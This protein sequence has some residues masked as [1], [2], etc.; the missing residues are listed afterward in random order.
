MV[1]EPQSYVIFHRDA[2]VRD[3]KGQDLDSEGSLQGSEITSKNSWW[4]WGTGR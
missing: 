3:W 2:Q 4:V 1:G